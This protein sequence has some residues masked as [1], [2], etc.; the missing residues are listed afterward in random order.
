M[1][2]TR[3]RHR[4]YALS[5]PLCASKVVPLR[6]IKEFGSERRAFCSR[7]GEGAGRRVTEV[8][9]KLGAEVRRLK[10]LLTE[11]NALNSSGNSSTFTHAHVPILYHKTSHIRIRLKASQ[12]SE[13]T[14]ALT[15]SERGMSDIGDVDNVVELRQLG[16]F[17]T[18]EQ[19]ILEIMWWGHHISSADELYHTVWDSIEGVTRISSPISGTIEGLPSSRD[20]DDFRGFPSKDLILLSTDVKSIDEGIASGRLV[21]SEE[22]FEWI[23]DTQD[24]GIFADRDVNHEREQDGVILVEAMLANDIEDLLDLRAE[25]QTTRF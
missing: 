6:S 14:A 21:S 7:W 22:Y 9:T 24:S 12:S 20:F 8:A 19:D 15:L 1:A 2:A 23:L 11:W 17:I 10:Q 3:S 25:A 18:H 13:L 16:D 5:P 4:L